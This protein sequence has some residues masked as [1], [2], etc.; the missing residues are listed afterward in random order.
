M[1]AYSKIWIELLFP[2]YVIFLVIMII[3]VSECSDKF[4][5]FIGKRNPVATLATLIL[6]SYA[7]LLN[8]IIKALSF[9]IIDYPGSTKVVRWLPDASVEFFRGKHI[10]LG[11]GALL[12]LLLCITFTGLVFSWQWLAYFDDNKILK[13]IKSQKMSHF[14][15]T[16]H[17]PYTPRNRYWT[18]LLLIVRVVLY[19]AS[20]INI[21]GNPN[22]N[23]LI[24]GLIISSVLFLKEITGINSRI[25][26]KWPTEILEASILINIVVLCTSTIFT[27]VIENEKAKEAITGTSVAI[28]LFQFLGVIFYHIFA[29]N[30]AIKKLWKMCSERN[31]HR[32]VLS[33][34]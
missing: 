32:A 33:R 25:Y 23:L 8:I 7:K 1:D 9:A 24:I 30:V 22:V 19:V 11:I 13:L 15:E 18:G 3:V 21:S 12:L 2:M 10:P 5:H 31:Y 20:S 14:I 17:A 16:Y 26:K 28:V 29:E 27:N 34:E 6:F 4:S